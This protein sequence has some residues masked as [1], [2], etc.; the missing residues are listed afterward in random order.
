[1]FPLL[2]VRG[3]SHQTLVFLPSLDI[4]KQ[5]VERSP[6]TDHLHEPDAWKRFEKL[7]YAPIVS[8]LLA[9]E[10]SAPCPF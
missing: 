4:A 6:V 8:G 2:G 3:S 7:R 1:L 9:D 10:K 5:Y